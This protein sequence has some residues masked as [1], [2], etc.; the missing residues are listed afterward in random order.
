MR[1]QPCYQHCAVSSV[2]LHLPSQHGLCCLSPRQAAAMLLLRLASSSQG[3]RLRLLKPRSNHCT[4]LS[5]SWSQRPNLLPRALP[6]Q[7]TLGEG[8]TRCIWHCQ[9]SIPCLL[10][11]SFSIYPSLTVK[12]PLLMSSM[13]TRV[14]RTLP[15]SWE[16]T[17]CISLEMP[18]TQVRVTLTN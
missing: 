10:P 17:G 16:L 2:C 11:P 14:P 4:S 6:F 9:S 7:V 8:L 5:G 13:T 12:H 3:H 18:I 15:Y 1:L